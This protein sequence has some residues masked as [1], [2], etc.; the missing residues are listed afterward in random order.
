MSS[1][2]TLEVLAKI[3]QC[4]LT[5][6]LGKISVQQHLESLALM[7]FVMFVVYRHNRTRFCPAQH[8][9]NVQAMVKVSL[10]I[11]RPR[12]LAPFSRSMGGAV[13]NCS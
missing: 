5:L 4:Y 7:A 12:L 8:Y 1:R 9:G 11:P 13:C 10:L 2:P 6:L 3:S